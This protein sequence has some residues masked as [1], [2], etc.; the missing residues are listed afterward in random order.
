MKLD[1]HADRLFDRIREAHDAAVDDT[2]Q[3]AVEIAGKHSKS[4]KFAASLQRTATVE[5]TNPYHNVLET[6]IGSPLASAKAKEKGAW[7]V[8]KRAPYLTIKTA[9][10]WR[11]IKDGV[12]LAP[13][14]AVTP[15]GRRFGELVRA[16]LGRT[17]V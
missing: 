10:G 8:P 2:L 16:R 5:D 6:R 17:G 7:I 15:A 11:R 12:R 14:P 1:S 4:G 13:Q 3:L 9:D